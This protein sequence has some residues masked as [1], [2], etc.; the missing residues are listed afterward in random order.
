[1]LTYA[2]TCF[3]KNKQET[4][5]SSFTVEEETGEHDDEGKH[6]FLYILILCVNFLAICMYS[7]Y[8]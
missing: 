4:I 8:Y 5:I 7:L 2:Q 3:W 6:F 1:M